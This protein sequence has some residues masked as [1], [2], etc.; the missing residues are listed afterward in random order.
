MVIPISAL[1]WKRNCHLSKENQETQVEYQSELKN[2]ML[3][4]KIAFGTIHCW[5]YMQ[6]CTQEGA[7][8]MV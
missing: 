4:W 3:F 1:T 2:T 7:G 8:A 6:W 5:K